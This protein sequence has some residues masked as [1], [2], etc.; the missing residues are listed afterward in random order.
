[1]KFPIKIIKSKMVD[2]QDGGFKMLSIQKLT[3]GV[4]FCS[5]VICDP[6]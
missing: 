1:M 2:F 3:C 5:F 6:R 4:K